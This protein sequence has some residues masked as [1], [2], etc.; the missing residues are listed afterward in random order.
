L[1]LHTSQICGT[2]STT[3]LPNFI[4]TKPNDNGIVNVEFAQPVSNLI[5]YMIGVDVFFDQFAVIDVYRSGSLYSSYPVFGNGTRTVGFTL[6]SLDNI[7]KIVIRNISDVLG[8]GFD[9]FTF[10]VP[11]DIKITSAR[12]SGYLNGTTQNALLGADITLQA[13]PVPS[14]FSGGSYTWTC[15]PQPLCAVIQGD[16]RCIFAIRNSDDFG[17]R[18]CPAGFG[19]TGRK[20]DPPY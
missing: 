3:S 7:S 1:P 13:T 10:N 14:G 16:L 18:S 9:D 5:F 12:V 8:I 6:G 19:Q 15:T 17:C 2:C 11:S 4:T 20:V